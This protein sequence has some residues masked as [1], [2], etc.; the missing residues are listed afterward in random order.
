VHI[1]AVQSLGKIKIDVNSLDID[2]MS[3]SAHKIHGPKGIGALYVRKGLVIKPFIEGGGQERGLRS[4]TENLPGASGFG[5][6]AQI[7]FEK[8][9]ENITAV[10]RIKSHF[11]EGLSEIPGA[12]INSPQD[13][14][15]I[16]NIL[17]VSF[18]RV[19][20]EVLLHAL[21]DYKI[22]V[23]TGSACSAKKGSHLNYVLPAIGVKEALIEGTI[24]FSFSYLNTPEEV[25][26]T[27]AALKKILP[28]LRRVKK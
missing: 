28:V 27:L 2:M 7:A 1:D 18:E 14:K 22:Y 6:A 13:D 20:G 25:D 8:L 26:K 21:E 4:G 11:I 16:D 23:S 19:P 3:L 9:E 10:Y 17:N 15:H 12:F 5:L 24:R